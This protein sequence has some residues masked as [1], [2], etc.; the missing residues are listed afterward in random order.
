ML[1]EC[2]NATE[3]P[4]TDAVYSPL[5]VRSVHPDDHGSEMAGRAT[6][7]ALSMLVAPAAAGIELA[8]MP[9]GVRFALGEPHVAAFRSAADISNDKVL[10]AADVAIM[11]DH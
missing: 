7:L 3:L 4:R 1:L 5:W 11:D 9:R 10:R 8:Y 6:G 2:V